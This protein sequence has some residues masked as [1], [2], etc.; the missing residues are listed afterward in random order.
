MLTQ[1]I[2]KI[3]LGSSITELEKERKDISSTITEE[4]SNLFQQDDII[5]QFKRCETIHEGYTGE[6]DQDKLDRLIGECDICLFLFKDKVGK[7]TRHEFEVARDYQKKGKKKPKIFVSFLRVPINDLSE[8]VL[9]NVQSLLNFKKHLE[10]E[11]I[12]WNEYDNLS[13]VKHGWV[14]GILNQL[15][16]TL[17][18]SP[19]EKDSDERF[20]Q[21]KSK[22]HQFEEN[23]EQMHQAIENLR[24]QI[25]GLIDDEND[26]NPD[27]IVQAL[28]LYK[29]ADLW[30][31]KTDY[32]KKK[33]FDLLFDYALLLYK[34]GHYHDA[35]EVYLR[36]IPLAERLYGKESPQMAS[37]YNNIGRV[38]TELNRYYEA[39]TYL[40]KELAILD[41]VPSRDKSA[42]YHDIVVVYKKLKKY[43]K[44]L[45]YLK[46]SED[47]YHS[48][49]DQQSPETRQRLAQIYN[50]IGGIYMDLEKLQE[51]LEMYKKALELQQ[52]VV[53]QNV[54]VLND[55]QSSKRYVGRYLLNIGV[56]YRKQGKYLRALWY[57]YRAMKYGKSTIGENHP[58]IANTYYQ[59]ALTYYDMKLYI[60]ARKYSQKGLILRKQF[61]GDN[62]IQTQASDTLHKKIEKSLKSNWWKYQYQRKKNIK[63]ALSKAMAGPLWKQMVFAVIIFFIAFIIVWAFYCFQ[64][65][66]LQKV[67]ADMVSPVT[68]RNSAYGT[69]Q[70]TDSCGGS[71]I[72]HNTNKDFWRY[73]L[74]HLIGTL[75]FTGI[76]IATITNIFRTW[77]DRFKNGVMRFR[78]FNRHTVFLGYDDMVPGMIAKLCGDEDVP[79]RI[80]IVVGVPDRVYETYMQLRNALPQRQRRCV[81][82]MKADCCNIDDLKRLNV[83]KAKDVYIIGAQ[84][85]AYSLNSYNRIQSICEKHRPECYVQ[86]QYLSTYALFQTYTKIEGMKYFHA[87]NFHNEWARKMLMKDD[88]IDTRNGVSITKDSDKQVHLVIVGMTEMGE[89][90]AREAAFLCHYPNFKEKGI[91]TKITFVD[92]QVKEPEKYFRGRYRHL[93]EAKFLDVEF[94]FLNNNIA[95]EETQKLIGSWANDE[96]QVLTIAACTD[97]PHRSM[98]AGLYL[99]DAVFEKKIPVWVY[100]PTKGDMASYL[101]SS[102]FGNVTTFGMSGKEL[103]IKNEEGI[104]RAKRLNHFYWHLKDNESIDY[105][106][107]E[108]I[109]RE[110][111]C[112]NVFDKWSNVYNVSAIPAKLRSVGGTIKESDVE[113]LAEVEHNRWNV[114]KLLMGFRPTTEEEH[115]QIVGLSKTTEEFKD[116]F[117]HDNI[118]PYS[119]L[120]DETK[121]IDRR[122]TREIPNIKGA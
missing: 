87:F 32:D 10:K 109:D 43:D 70:P 108:T 67:Y 2:I 40:K 47:Y 38:Y 71:V 51:S 103:D 105:S 46:K 92:P 86:M 119:E 74:A 99:P 44:A 114:E 39:L 19:A 18:G 94:E 54:A 110:W 23:K 11:G 117:I 116:N 80:R 50:T 75:A 106:D 55:A 28:E 33:H 98:A 31:S 120:D 95:D 5:I 64:S 101:G 57:L 1:K 6:P 24:T 82:V 78:S 100:Q 115:N 42:A 49:L 96:K 76:L 97:M 72:D 13:E 9:Q 122:F 102:C 88:E 12:H 69:I 58:N 41:N 85:D 37:L 56:A 83:H 73:L 68:L 90:L 15:G 30:A 81:V 8:E 34:V 35:E 25:P 48:I 26:L 61:F 107:T 118:R 112:C 89:A 84:D 121:K 17:D 66:N 77:G 27:L 22:E 53:I 29:K 62:N 45:E 104:R 111:D 79:N 14:L 36:Q 52:D 16:I 20:E 91:R 60:K 4:I 113:I 21:I 93:L 65:E 59:I 3:F 7:Y 63:L